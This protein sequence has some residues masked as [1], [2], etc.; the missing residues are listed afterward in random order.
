MTTRQIILDTETTGLYADGGDRLV[1]FAGLEMVNRQMTDK[2]LHLYVHPERDMP[3]EAARVHGLT[4]EVLEGKNA[5]P[6]AEVGRQI[7]DFLRGAELII[8]NAKFDVGFLNMEFRR[9]GLPT[10]EELGCTVT[11][12]LAM[13]REMFPGQKASL[14]ALCNR[15]SVDRSKRV[16]HG[17]LIDCEL[18]GEVYLAMTR[19]QFDLMG[20]AAEEKMETKPVAH[21]ETKRSGKLKVIRAD[22]NELAEHGRYL[23]G[24]GEACI[25]RKTQMPSENGGTEA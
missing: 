2:N 18:L 12:T 8:H 19:R 9:M 1:E 4:I 6:F 15:F 5:P 14:D 25:W 10:V 23:D 13:A 7:A 20:A 16:L 17:A 3:E 22:E 21:T 11:D 24:L